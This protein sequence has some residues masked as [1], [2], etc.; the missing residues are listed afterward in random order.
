MFKKISTLI[1]LSIF[2]SFSSSA[3]ILQNLKKTADKAEETLKGA[4]SGNNGKL[5]EAEVA[6]GLK[7][8]LNQGV[9]KGVSKLSQA[10]G[11]LNDPKV[12]IPMPD[13][14]KKVES[15]LRQIG[16]G[17]MVDDAIESM[18]KAAE[19]AATEAKDLFVKAIKNMTLKDAMSILKGNDDAATQ[20]LSKST[21]ADLML[22]F[23]PIIKSSL[24]KV[25]A[26]KYWNTTFS[27]YNKI[28]FAKKVNPN[29][30]DYVTQKALD[31][32]FIQVAQEEL[33]IR[34]D[35]AARVSDL[36]KKVFG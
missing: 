19:D 25:N 34:K 21:R 29:L 14:A 17:K 27:T 16:Q 10:G 5:S 4:T 33:A 1:T 2:L 30:E 18:N 20:Y 36:L 35:P 22:K 8:A 32:L 15:K 6:K 7:E 28:P 12:K 26:T 23:K 31:G 13:E 24:E 9:E 11:Y 3:Q